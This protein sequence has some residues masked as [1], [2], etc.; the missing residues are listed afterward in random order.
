[1][2]TNLFRIELREIYQDRRRSSHAV[3][4]LMQGV[5]PTRNITN[6][7][8]KSYV[9]LRELSGSHWTVNATINAP[10][11]PPSVLKPKRSIAW[12]S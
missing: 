4:R 2:F 12:R 5:K 8:Q 1:M 10:S 9:D 7:G 3:V 6:E 11:R